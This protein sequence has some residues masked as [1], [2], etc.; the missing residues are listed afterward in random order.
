MTLRPGRCY[1]RLQR[2]YTRI[3]IH[4]P[5]KSY[6]VG[7]PANKI[8]QFEM[9]AKKK[10]FSKV[11]HLAPVRSVQIRDNALEASRQGA[12]KYLEKTLTMEN[13]FLK[14]LVYPY[15]VL[16]ENSLATGAG[17]D[18]FQEGMR[19]SFGKPIGTAA[20]IM[21]NQPIM[22]LRV[23]EGSEKIAKRALDVASKKVPGE[24]RIVELR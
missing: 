13:Y 12:N 9:G 4:V 2:P 19:K 1:S 18:R 5:R 21:K 23:N 22:E 10:N 11:F 16:R 17:A 24:C 20:R 15:Q 8:T 14:V 3:S 7:V 6:V